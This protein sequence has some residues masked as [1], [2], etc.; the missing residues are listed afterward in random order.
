MRNRDRLVIHNWIKCFEKELKDVPDVKK[1]LT[2]NPMWHR[3]QA[4]IE[5]GK[6]LLE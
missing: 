3:L 6:K 4:K 1:D 2:P 5:F